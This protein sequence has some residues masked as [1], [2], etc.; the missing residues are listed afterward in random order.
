[1]DEWFQ[2][3]DPDRHRAAAVVWKQCSNN[4][5]RTRHVKETGVRWS[6]LLRLPYFNPIRHLV[7]DPMHNLFLGL[8]KWIVMDIWLEE[9]K[10]SKQNLKTI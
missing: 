1:M 2:D 9:G 4:A 7:V 8:V 6:E 5:E 10:L 3:A